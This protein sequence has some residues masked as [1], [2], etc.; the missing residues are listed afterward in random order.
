VSTSWS[1]PDPRREVVSGVAFGVPYEREEPVAPPL[2]DDI[3]A[4]LITFF[5]TVLAG[6]PVGLLW[7]VLAPRV[8]V[9]VVGQ[10]VNLV[11]AYGDGFIAADAYFLAAVFVAGLVAGVLAWKLGSASGPVVVVALAAGGILAAYVAMTVG[12]EVGAPALREAVQ[13][14]DGKVFELPVKVQAPEAMI[15]W[16]LAS[17]LAFLSASLTRRSS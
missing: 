1:S 14:S 5:V 3:K 17:M 10:D 13:R 11:E 12:H 2:R 15:G 7:S 9:V 16:P 4:G 6:V 8:E